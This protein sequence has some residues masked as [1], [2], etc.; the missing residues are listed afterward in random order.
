MVL[1]PATSLLLSWQR[2]ILVH[3]KQTSPITFATCLEVAIIIVVL[4]WN[5]SY[6]TY[7]GVTGAALALVLG[8]LASVA[9][10]KWK[11]KFA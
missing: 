11:L 10:L 6:G 3:Q 5:I 2:A 4:S 8:R 1:I 7:S 9:Y